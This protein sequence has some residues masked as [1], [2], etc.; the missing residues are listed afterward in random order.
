[1]DAEL[2]EDAQFEGTFLDNFSDQAFKL[3]TGLLYRKTTDNDG[4]RV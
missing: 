4:E 2:S 1:M 3:P